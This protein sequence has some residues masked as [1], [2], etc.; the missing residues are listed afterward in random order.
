MT[1]NENLPFDPEVDPSENEH[2]TPSMGTADVDE[3]EES[4]N[5]DSEVVEN[6][7]A[8]FLE[9]EEDFDDE[10]IDDEEEEDPNSAGI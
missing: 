3:T 8:D 6:D 9:D 4:V 2:T 10:E 5:D 1:N 7:D